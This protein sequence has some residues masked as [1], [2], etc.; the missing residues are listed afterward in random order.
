MGLKQ[1]KGKSLLTNTYFKVLLPP[2]SWLMAHD[3]MGF[4]DTFK[5]FFLCITFCNTL[6]FV[7]DKIIFMYL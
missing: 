2:D 5:V 7:I 1:R 4:W 6:G 3:T